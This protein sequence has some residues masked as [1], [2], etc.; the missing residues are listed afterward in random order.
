MVKK[1]IYDFDLGELSVKD[2]LFINI[3]AA[4]TK[5]KAVCVFLSKAIADEF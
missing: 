1:E 3:V 2:K 4:E 5:R